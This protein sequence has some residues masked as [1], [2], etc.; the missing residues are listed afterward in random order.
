MAEQWTA[1]VHAVTGL[2][3]R[4]PDD[5]QRLVLLV[6]SR[7]KRLQNIET[8]AR[9]S[10]IPVERLPKQEMDRLCSLSHQ[11]VLARV[12]G[13]SPIRNERDLLVLLDNLEETPLLL[14]LDGVTDPH[15]LGAC[16]RSADAAGVHGVILPKD[17]SA[18]LNATVRKVASGAAESIPVFT[19]TNLARCLDALKQRGIWLVGTCDTA[20]ETL[21]QR[22]LTGPT[23]LLLGAEG[24]GLRR[25][26]RE[27]CDF[28][29][30]LPMLGAVSSL[31]VSVAAGICLFEAVRQRRNFG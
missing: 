19:V 9:D 22:D 6:G 5:V 31:N 3:K 29:A 12:S 30:A 23:A 11:G 21:Y 25:L 18:P 8:L 14:V 2:L 24:K 16:L 15:N 1:G 7:N 10:G 20:E 28:L 13:N 17:K 27:S 4:H 26:T